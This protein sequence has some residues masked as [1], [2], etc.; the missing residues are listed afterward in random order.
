MPEAFPGGDEAFEVC[1]VCDERVLDLCEYKHGNARP[2]YK[3]RGGGRGRG[4]GRGR[5][6]RGRPID[7]KM[8]F[9]G[10]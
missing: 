3:G 1:I 8:T 9:H 2:H 6:G 4:R 7:A 10:F 5:R